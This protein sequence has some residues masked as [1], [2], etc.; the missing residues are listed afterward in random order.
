VPWQ[1]DRDTQLFLSASSSP[2]RFGATIYNALFRRLEINAVYLSRPI[3][4]ARSLASAI[5]TL[6]V[7]GCSVSM[8][9][10][11]QIIVNLDELDGDA[12]SVRS[13]NT[14]HN[15][16]GKLIGYNTDVHGVREALKKLPY[17]AVLVYGSGS[18]VDSIMHVLEGR[19][20][21][22]E[23]R[24]RDKRRMVETRWRVQPYEGQ[25][26]D[27]FINA[28]PMSL[29]RIPDPIVKLLPQ[30]VFDL[31]LQRENNHLEAVS[32]TKGLR[33]VPGFEMYQHQ[34]VKQFEL[35]TGH[36]VDLATVA[37][38]AREHGLI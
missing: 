29:E 7:R 16:D 11:N 17:E 32:K 10:K 37:S 34:F 38:V 6:G 13:V 2:S 30:T 26:I 33:Y 28:T 9:L 5:R 31:V 27:L 3:T 15:V 12:E 4:N 1:P 8:P 35:Y 36:S 22:V 21:F 25:P 19:Q 24:D 20:V 23:A 14:V 18:V